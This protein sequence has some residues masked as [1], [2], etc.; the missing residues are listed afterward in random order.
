MGVLESN[1]TLVGM[2]KSY[3]GGVKLA[4]STRT[5]S[6]KVREAF[7][8]V[9]AGLSRQGVGTFWLESELLRD[10]EVPG[11]PNLR[12]ITFFG[13]CERGGQEY[14][15][16]EQVQIET[17][18]RPFIETWSFSEQ[19]AFAR[20]SLFFVNRGEA[21]TFYQ[22]TADPVLR[23]M[24]IPMV[25]SA[26]QLQTLKRNIQLVGISVNSG[27]RNSFSANVTVLKNLLVDTVTSHQ[28]LATRWYVFHTVL[29]GKP[30]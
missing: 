22:V 12:V 21:F 15:F 24:P 26:T 2:R 13:R 16:H 10:A 30:I 6:R 28:I 5:W 3:T 4:L 20:L 18:Q 8:E 14:S 11:K 23:M 7:V 25:N 27:E 29:N 17:N 9:S 19:S 1:T